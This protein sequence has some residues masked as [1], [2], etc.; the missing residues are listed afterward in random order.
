MGFRR[1]GWHELLWIGRVLVLIQLVHGVVGWG[2][3]GHYAVCKI[4]EV[5][6]LSPFFNLFFCVLSVAL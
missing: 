3:D 4:A 1:M 6:L 2:K 5:R